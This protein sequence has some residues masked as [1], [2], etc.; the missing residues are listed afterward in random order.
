MQLGVQLYAFDKEVVQ[1]NP[2]FIF[3]RLAEIGYQARTSVS[4]A[5]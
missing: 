2:D 3:R 1:N 4:P 5:R